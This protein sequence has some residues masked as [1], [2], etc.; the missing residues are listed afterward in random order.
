MTMTNVLT[1]N[2]RNY[3]QFHAVARK[4]EGVPD[5]DVL[6]NINEC[7]NAMT[8]F[9]Q[10]YANW[11]NSLY[12]NNIQWHLIVE[13]IKIL[14]RYLK[15]ADSVTEKELEKCKPQGKRWWSKEKRFTRLCALRAARRGKLHFS[16]TSHTDQLWGRYQIPKG[17]PHTEI[18]ETIDLA[19]QREWVEPLAEEFYAQS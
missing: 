14:A 16:S 19:V 2:Y 15:D 17:Y 9:E 13:Q 6:R 4:S 18:P 3:F 5:P 11:I 10:E 8:E 7:W 1:D 12:A